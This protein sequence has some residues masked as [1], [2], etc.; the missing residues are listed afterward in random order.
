[1]APEG[2]HIPVLTIIKKYE[3]AFRILFIYLILIQAS[4]VTY[5]AVV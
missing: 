3:S 5:R 4:N 2:P 1:M